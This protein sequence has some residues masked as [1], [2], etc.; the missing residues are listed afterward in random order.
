MRN[1]TLF[2]HELF[3]YS[4][5]YFFY[6]LLAFL[7]FSFL[8]P[9]INGDGGKKE[10]SKSRGD[11]NVECLTQNYGEDNFVYGLANNVLDFVNAFI[12]SNST[13]LV[14]LFVAYLIYLIFVVYI[15]NKKPAVNSSVV[16]AAKAFGSIGTGI[17]SLVYFITATFV[18]SYF[19]LTIFVGKCLFNIKN[20]VGFVL[21]IYIFCSI[22]IFWLDHK[23]SFVL[24]NFSKPKAI[25][26]LKNKNKKWYQFGQPDHF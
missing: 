9:I 13:V 2:L 6:T 1:P 3:I 23:I 24:T 26:G 15:K 12:P 20:M 16:Y 21:L 7:V 17:N 18:I 10:V 8:G 4:L 11:S 5:V 14:F 25:L 22:F 19:F